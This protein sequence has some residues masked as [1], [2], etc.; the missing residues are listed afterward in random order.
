MCLQLEAVFKQRLQHAKDLIAVCRDIGLGL[1]FIVIR[2]QPTWTTHELERLDTVCVLHENLQRGISGKTARQWPHAH[3]PVEERG[4]LDGGHLELKP[5][6]WVRAFVR[7][8]WRRSAMGRAA[9][10]T[11]PSQT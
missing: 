11:P 3:D 5:W 6:R 2:R 1:D 9:R 8:R 4:W 10:A 7:A